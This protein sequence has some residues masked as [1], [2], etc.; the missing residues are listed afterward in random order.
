[1]IAPVIDFD[2]FVSW[3]NVE[4]FM[5]LEDADVGTRVIEMQVAHLASPEPLSNHVH[6]IAALSEWAADF[7]HEQHPDF[8]R[9]KIV[10]FP[11]GV[12]LKSFPEADEAREMFPARQFI[13][14]SSPD[15]G[16]HHLLRMW[17]K[18][19][20]KY[21]LEDGTTPSLHVCYGIE[22]FVNGS[23]WSHKSDA[24]RA[25]TITELIDQPGVV[26][27]GKV[28]QDKLH[29]LMSHC[30]ALLYPCDTMSHTETGCITIVEALAA[31]IEVVTTEA[32]CLKSEFGHMTRQVPLPLDY[33]DYIDAVDD[34]ISGDFVVDKP[35]RDNFLL[36]RD[37]GFIASDWTDWAESL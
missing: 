18:I 20:E 27:H 6:Y 30:D 7:L 4:V 28:G 36:T 22:N 24:D 29:T 19:Y 35:D 12:D 15:R 9:E 13:Y 34:V 32:D 10:V 17:P 23:R 3:E 26:Y 8:P 21:T 25:L 5:Q 33:E 2:L 37:W 11:N 16:L 31:G 1:M 14:S